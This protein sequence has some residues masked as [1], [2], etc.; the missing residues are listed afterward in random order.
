[1]TQRRIFEVTLFPHQEIIPVDGNI[2]WIIDPDD[3]GFLNNLLNT[4]E[5]GEHPQIDG[6]IGQQEC[7][8]KT[9]RIHYHFV[10]H[11]RYAMRY[12]K[13]KKLFDNFNPHVKGVKSNQFYERINYVTKL[14][15]R[16]R[17]PWQ[18][19]VIQ[20]QGSRSDLNIAINSIR[21]G[22]IKSFDELV[23]SFP[24]L[25]A[26]YTKFLKGLLAK[27]AKPRSNFTPTIIIY[28][29]PGT[30]KDKLARHIIETNHNNSFYKVNY[31]KDNNELW[32]KDYWNQEV[33]L[34]SEFGPSIR[35]KDLLNLMDRYSHKVREDMLNWV[36][37]NPKAM[38]FTSVRDPYTWYH[39]KEDRKELDRR[40]KACCI[41]KFI[42][43][44]KY[45]CEQK[46]RSL[47]DP[48]IPQLVKK[49]VKEFN[50]RYKTNK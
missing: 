30:G 3:V 41:Y 5:Q 10:L 48:T 40:L 6:I 2:E 35:Y 23:T 27:Q 25:S 36:Q 31:P 7:G 11:T 45:I 24:I 39:K 22:T 14:E 19:G 15:T 47:N 38:I 46:A 12:T 20:K 50:F 13:V 1:M 42:E 37:F 8:K 16:M 21:D 44:N 33:V 29:N 17:G 49:K 18:Y 34:F 28:G 9:N 32:F 4:I 26:K 43:K